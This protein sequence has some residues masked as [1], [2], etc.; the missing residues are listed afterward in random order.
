[1]NPV[2]SLL[3]IDGIALDVDAPS[4]KRAFEELSLLFEKI[5]GVP[6]RDA[7]DAL[8]SRERLGCTALGGGVAIP[9]GRIQGL[10]RIIVA[11]LRTKNPV[12]FDTPDNRRARL[13]FGILIPADDE[14]NYL[15]VLA[16][17]AGMLRNRTVKDALL[18]QC[19]PLELCQTVSNYVPQDSEQDK[20]TQEEDSAAGES[21][22]HTDSA[23]SS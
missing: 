2:A 12:V 10:D 16:T 9:H 19:S 11:I 3:T 8:N 15:P 13:F 4:R 18:N 6:H 22:T 1:M 5:A 20:E 17:V 21:P 7:F 23:P 14:E